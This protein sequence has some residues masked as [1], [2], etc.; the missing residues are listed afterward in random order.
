MN[1]L[2]KTLELLDTLAYYAEYAAAV[3]LSLMIL[4]GIIITGYFVGI[5]FYIG[6]AMGIM[7]GATALWILIDTKFYISRKGK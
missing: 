6:L 3:L 2:D 4:I 7:I 5:G 1:K